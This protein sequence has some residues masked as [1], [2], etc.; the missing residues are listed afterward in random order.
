[1]STNIRSGLLRTTRSDKVRGPLNNFLKA[2]RFG[3][4]V[5][6]PQ[7][8]GQGAVNF[9]IQGRDEQNRNSLRLRIFPQQTT[10]PVA[11]KLR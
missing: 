10:N 8:L 11:V 9:V 6:G 5:V 3:D 7:D 4:Q 1:M 2:K